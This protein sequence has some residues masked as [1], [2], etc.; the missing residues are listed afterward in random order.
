MDSISTQHI[1]YHTLRFLFLAFGAV[2]IRPNSVETCSLITPLKQNGYS[3]YIFS[4]AYDISMTSNQRFYRTRLIAFQLTTTTSLSSS[5][6][7][8]SSIY[9]SATTTL[10]FNSTCNS[11]SFINSTS[12]YTNTTSLVCILPS[13]HKKAF[14]YWIFYL[15]PLDLA[16]AFV[17]IIILILLWYLFGWAIK[18]TYTGTKKGVKNV[19]Q[20]VDKKV[21]QTRDWNQERLKRKKDREERELERKRGTI[22]LEAIM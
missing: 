6:D 20:G 21:G 7:P 14:P 1:W 15:W 19:R 13:K 10:Y 5:A 18:G 11:T 2:L 17:A 12:S 8:T 3:K 4:L 22:A 16:L 9:P